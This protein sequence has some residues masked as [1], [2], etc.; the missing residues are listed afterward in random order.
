MAVMSRV[1]YLCV[2][3]TVSVTCSRWSPLPIA[4]PV[5]PA[6]HI[7]LLVVPYLKLD[8]SVSQEVPLFLDLYSLV[9]AF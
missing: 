4:Q 8:E 9:I 6:D 3:I 2:L 1:K 7:I 5:F